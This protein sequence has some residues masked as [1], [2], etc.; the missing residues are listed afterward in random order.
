MPIWE[1]DV[2]VAGVDG[3]PKKKYGGREFPAKAG[4]SELARS[5]LRLVLAGMVP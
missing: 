4:L 5:W 1:S 3:C 2:P